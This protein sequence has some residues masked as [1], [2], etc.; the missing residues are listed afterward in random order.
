[1]Y[2][3]AMKHLQTNI[4]LSIFST[5]F[6]LKHATK[7]LKIGSQ[8]KII[9]TKIFSNRDYTL[10]REI[11][12]SVT[13]ISGKSI[14]FLQ[15]FGPHVSFLYY[16]YIGFMYFGCRITKPT[17]WP[18]RSANTQISLG[19]RPVWSKSS[20]SAWRNIGSLTSYWVHS[21]DWSDCR[22]PGWSESSLGAHLILLVLSCDG[23]SVLPFTCSSIT[24]PCRVVSTHNV[25]F[26]M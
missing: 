15:V 9:Y 5:Y 8:I 10:T 1:M 6:V 16:F 26:L 21:E 17:K 14:N 2:H 3:H 13:L 18:V 19:I 22:M 23:S 7:N 4:I 12:K 20:L 24:V 25:L 11:I